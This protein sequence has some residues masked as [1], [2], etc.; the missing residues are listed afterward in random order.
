MYDSGLLLRAEIITKV[1]REETVL[2]FL[3]ECADNRNRDSQWM[4][5]NIY[6]DIIFIFAIKICFSLF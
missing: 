3:R 1:M 2:D 6:Y 4:V 5:S